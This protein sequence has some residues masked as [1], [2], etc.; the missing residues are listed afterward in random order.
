MS[1]AV[2][3]AVP[4]AKKPGIGSLRS[5][6]DPAGATKRHS[7]SF[8]ELVQAHF[9]RENALRNGT[10]YSGPDEE[11]YREF[12]AAFERR[13]GPIVNA[14]WCTSTPSA[15]A[16]TQREGP[17]RSQ[18]TMR[19]H[20]VSD[21]ATKEEPEIA[22]ALHECDELAVRAAQVL[23]GKTMQICMQLVMASAG[24]LLSL[25]DG[26]AEHETKGKK[27]LAL[28]LERRKLEKTRA[29]YHQA[30]NGQAQFY[31]FGGMIIGALVLGLLSLA[32]GFTYSLPG[33]DNRDFFGSLTAGTL[34][35][36]V[37]VMARIG[38]G[39]FR[40]DYDVGRRYPIFLGALRPVIGAIFGVALYF[41]VTSSLLDV[42][43][44]P[45][46]PD[47][48]FYFLLVIAFLAGFSE[49]WARDTLLSF[50]GPAPGSA[51]GKRDGIT[52]PVSG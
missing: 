46:N 34:G 36:L 52:Q 12:E 29:Y 33:I 48:R 17:K 7:V 45:K 3:S 15:V 5:R 14:Y 11:R 32:I 47:Q 2:E 8:S 28:R 19:L 26:P 42:F 1:G 50:G 23:R 22:D 30:A 43:K 24:H 38:S 41:A 51:A 25:V 20:R 21:W 31:Y 49:R 40:L 6:T 35:A 10:I 18:Q 37:S 27:E 39:Q 44:L 16:L 9:I 13:H 4:E